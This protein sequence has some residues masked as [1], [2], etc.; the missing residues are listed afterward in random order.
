M[1]VSTGKYDFLRVEEKHLIATLIGLFITN[2][3]L[4]A[5][6]T[7]AFN[8][9]YLATLVETSSKDLN[10]ALKVADSLYRIS[11][12]PWFQ[13]RS[14]L[15][16][17]YLCQGNREYRRAIEYGE[18]AEEIINNTNLYKW[19]ANVN[20][21]LAGQY[22]LLKLY[23]ESKAYEDK[24]LL[25]IKKVKDTQYAAI[26][27][28]FIMQEKA[29]YEQDIKHYALSNF[30][31]Y[32]AEKYFKIAK[33]ET[34]LNSE[35]SYMILGRN[36]YYLKKY[37]TAVDCYHKGL[38][39]GKSFPDNHY[40]KGFLYGGLAEVYL[41]KNMMD[42]AKQ[43]I[44]KAEK[45]ADLTAFL[46]AKEVVYKTAEAYYAKIGDIEHLR[47]VQAKKDSVQDAMNNKAFSYVEQTYSD[48]KN[49]NKRNNEK[50]QRI[51][52][53]VYMRI[54]VVLTA[55]I[56]FLRYRKKQKQKV[57]RLQQIIT[58]L[59]EKVGRFQRIIT[60]L[61]EKITTNKNEA[62][63]LNIRPQSKDENEPD[64]SLPNDPIGKPEKNND[65]QLMPLETE[66]KILDG[67]ANFEN[68]G[69]FRDKNLS[70]SFLAS[71]LSTNSKYLSYV[72]KKHKEKDFNNYINH[73]RINY[74]I[75]KLQVDSVWRQY[76][77]SI[78]A[79]EGGFSSHSKFATIFKQLVGTPPSVFIQQLDLKEKKDR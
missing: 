70:L 61:R 7:A 5:Q 56:G 27:M 9:V 54:V 35:D 26:A 17:S 78:L 2:I 4:S 77:M 76:K 74:I 57:G 49:E 14:L 62:V 30:Y 46:E 42:S 47:I 13:T 71:Y 52:Y 69:L 28:A 22:R 6:D 59:K 34:D 60:H 45:I 43:Y 64:P 48:L 12:S 75:Q 55:V 39:L 11:G 8:K 31:V 58:H 15:L 1:G 23:T 51:S 20:N 10:N 29:Y 16:A 38:L 65:E 19:Q 33:Q 73:L 18:R 40:V 24:A 66:K 44:T 32:E 37:D 41:A 63:F 3:S 21:T 25:A 68:S 72:I 36:Y 53:L 50:L 79:E 67:L